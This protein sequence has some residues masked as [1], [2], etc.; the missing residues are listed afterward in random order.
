M[1]SSSTSSTILMI[2]LLLSSSMA[3]ADIFLTAENL[4]SSLKDMQRLQRQLHNEAGQDH[5]EIIYQLGV[6]ADSLAKLLTDEVAAHGPQNEGLISLALERT[7]KIGINISWYGQNQSFYYDGSAFEQYL[8]A[9]PEGQH[10]ADSLYRQI[11][12]NFYLIVD[13][14][15]RDL[16]ASTKIG[17]AHV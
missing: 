5:S 1:N 3:A 6:E 11:K 13:G 15:A 17:R 14:S 12:R 10:V 4:N 2:V 9:S 16:I 7:E 8:Q